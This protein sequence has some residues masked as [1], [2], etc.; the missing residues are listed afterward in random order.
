[1]KKPVLRPDHQWVQQQIA[2][3]AAVLA[4]DRGYDSATAVEVAAAIWQHAGKAAAQY[5]ADIEG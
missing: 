4:A 3:L 5:L 1:M 2:T